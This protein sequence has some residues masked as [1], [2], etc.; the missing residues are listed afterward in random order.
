[1]LPVSNDTK[2]MLLTRNA[3]DFLLEDISNLTSGLQ[4]FIQKMAQ[5]IILEIKLITMQGP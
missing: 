4:Y 5:Y 2:F 3:N 1:M